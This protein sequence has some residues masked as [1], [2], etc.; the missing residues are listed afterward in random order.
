MTP[1]VRSSPTKLLAAL[2]LATMALPAAA[3]NAGQNAA[4]N[5]EPGCAVGVDRNGQPL[6]RAVSGLAEM[7]HGAV[8]RIDSSY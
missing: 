8:A 7:E 5:A 3:Q 6:L 4:P 2:L 1:A